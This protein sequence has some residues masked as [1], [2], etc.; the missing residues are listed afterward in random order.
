MGLIVDEFLDWSDH[1]N[2]LCCKLNGI[3]YS[4]RVI[5]KYMNRETLNVI[6][7]ANFESTL[8]FGIIFWGRQSNI[9]DA[10]IIQKKVIR[11]IHRMKFRQSCRSI[12]RQSN[13]M[14]TYG[15]YIYECLIFLF[16]HKEKFLVNN[17]D[18]RTTDIN[19]PVHRL[20]LSEKSPYYMCIKLFNKLP[21]T[22]RPL[23]NLDVIKREVKKII[24]EIEPYTLEEFFSYKF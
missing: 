10:F 1:I 24:V 3:C 23:S 9:Q 14:T 6:Y 2:K 22:I 15:L 20:T 8:K 19:Y 16:K 13:I 7:Y 5:S 11:I 4:I 17:Y 18:T 12:F 21:E